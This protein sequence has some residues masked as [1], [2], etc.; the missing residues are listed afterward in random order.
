MSC[1][2]S[3]S[4]ESC[5]MCSPVRL[6]HPAGRQV[7]ARSVSRLLLRQLRRHLQPASCSNRWSIFVGCLLVL[8]RY[9]SNVHDSSSPHGSL[10]LSCPACTIS[11]SRLLLPTSATNTE[12]TGDAAPGRD[13]A[14][15]DRVVRHH[16]GRG[17]PQQHYYY[18]YYY[19]YY[20]LLL[21]LF[22]LLSLLLSLLQFF[23]F[24][25]L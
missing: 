3:C 22:I 1:L 5:G 2:R 24:F 21:L 13:A 4:S 15:P 11:D 10:S 9:S 16:P 19:Y 12:S 17:P 25:L 6:V 7:F 23:F 20:Y 18:Y 8:M 14:G